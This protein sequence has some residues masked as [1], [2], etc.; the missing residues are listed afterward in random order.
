MTDLWAGALGTSFD[1]LS[2]GVLAVAPRFFVALIVFLVGWIIASGIG[3]LVEQFIKALKVDV[4]LE[5][6]GVR[7]PLSRAG[8]KLNSSMFIGALVRWFFIIVFLLAAVDVL[9]LQEVTLFLRDILTYLPN[10]IVAALI[11]VAAT[12]IADFSQK[13]ITG[14]AK[15]AGVPSA[16]FMGGVVR[17]AIWIF[18]ILAALYHLGVA[19]PLI[20][21]LFTGFVAMIALAGGLAFGLGGKDAA[22]RFLERLRSDISR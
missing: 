4:V 16:H 20:Q 18:A 10:V 11:L 8:V 13:F 19:G 22:A 15:A 7:D 1:A 6:L 12:L 2:Q 17:W 5:S 21:T 9:G 3:T 14:S